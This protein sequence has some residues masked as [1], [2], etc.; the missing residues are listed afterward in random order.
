M[1]WSL[2]IVSRSECETCTGS[3][4]FSEGH[5]NTGMGTFEAVPAQVRSARQAVP[6]KPAVAADGRYEE[7]S[8]SASP[9]VI[10]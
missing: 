2:C 3:L 6:R 8:S 10:L 5:N 1:E 4:C 9:A 7:L